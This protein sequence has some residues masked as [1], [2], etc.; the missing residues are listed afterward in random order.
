MALPKIDQPIFELTI[1]S[2]K[3][4]VKMRPFLVKEEK[5]LMMGLEAG[6]SKS[7]SDSLKQVITNCSLDEVN[8]DK[9][10]SFD[11]EY[12]FLKLRAHSISEVVELKFQCECS[13]SMPFEV[14]LNTIAIK[15]QDDHT[16]N[17]KLT[18]SIGIIMKYPTIN[19]IGRAGSDSK[20]DETFDLIIGCMES[21]YD[22]NQVYAI[23]DQTIAET[24]S[25]LETLNKEH[26]LKI[27]EFFETM[28]KIKYETN[29]ECPSC[30]K[31]S[32]V[33]IEGLNN[34]FH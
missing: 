21:I 19:D 33:E 13:E 6:D 14:D 22:D 25:W 29:L 12:I 1:P 34:F 7:I 26:Y 3:T 17:I 4:K 31:E 5:L 18:D 24:K 16:N 28:P 23:A 15:E 30:K 11:L 10:A 8:V 9:L 2:S 27:R 20:L 32:H